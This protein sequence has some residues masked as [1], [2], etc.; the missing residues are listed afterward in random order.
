MDLFKLKK[1]LFRAASK[2]C[3]LANGI[4]IM[5]SDQRYVQHENPKEDYFEQDV[6][7]YFTRKVRQDNHEFGYLVDNIGMRESWAS[8]EKD[9][10][11]HRMYD[12]GITSAN[13]QKND[14]DELAPYEDTFLNC[15][16]YNAFKDRMIRYFNEENLT[17]VGSGMVRVPMSK[18]RDEIKEYIPVAGMML[19]LD[20]FYFVRKMFNNMDWFCFDNYKLGFEE[21]S[22][23]FHISDLKEYG[24][25]NPCLDKISE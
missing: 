15:R 6:V 23:I 1:D 5:A 11:L 25:K 8:D 13:K 12:D 9:E 22:F 16:T 24:I 21:S 19:P 18:I 7:V 14:C 10:Y 20:L 3:D 2:H 4:R 17:I